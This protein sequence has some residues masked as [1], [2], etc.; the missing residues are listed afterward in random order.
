[1]SNVAYSITPISKGHKNSLK[2]CE[3]YVEHFPRDDK[4][5]IFM[6]AESGESGN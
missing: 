1:M 6:K 3:N 2:L 5:N 4:Q